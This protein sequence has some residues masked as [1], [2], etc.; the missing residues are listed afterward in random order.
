MRE[1]AGAPVAEGL[2]LSRNQIGA[3]MRHRLYLTAAA[4][5]LLAA[6]SPK[7]APG[8]SAG[9]VGAEAA[10]VPV[11][12]FVVGAPAGPELVRAAG[13]VRLRR[14]TPLA[15]WTA[16][17]VA[18]LR[19]R[20]GD[21]VAAGAVLASLD[22]RTIDMDVAA[23]RAD[24][25]R[26]RSDLERQRALVKQGW[27]TRA[28]LEA[29]EAAASSAGAALER[30]A[31]AQANARIRAP[32]AGIVLR[33]QAEPG[34]TVAAGDPVLVL[35][36]YRAGHVLRVPLTAAEVAG[37]S[38][39]Q[40]ADIRFSDGAA[41]DMAGKIIEIAGRA[42]ER[43]GSFQVEI[44]LPA[45]PGLRSG[46]IATAT[47]R[48]ARQAGT[49]KLMVPATALFAARAGEAFVWRHDA[50]AGKVKA[51]LVRV[52][53]VGDRGVEVLSG[54]A[55]GDRIVATGVDRLTE[56]ARVAVAG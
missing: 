50:A 44:A 40:G 4:L 13:T 36:E 3:A 1:G 34:Q 11:R 54:L 29:A 41:P 12:L 35:G 20:E 47:L 32:A 19:V 9:A 42:D 22:T 49:G 39:G 30:A 45:A 26:A 10:P 17:R 55:A 8:E 53:A 7:T 51:A 37:L 48:P 24:L 6:C 15:F 27:Q 5:G 38:V 56:G 33:R 23:A 28:R 46:Q 31:F 25:A 18:D 14:E 43:T 52:G 21:R 2:E 16:G